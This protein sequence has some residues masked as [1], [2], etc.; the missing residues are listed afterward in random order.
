MGL[1]TGYEVDPEDSTATA[2]FCTVRVAPYGYTKERD[3]WN[4]PAGH[5]TP[6]TP[7]TV[8]P[9]HGCVL[10]VRKP[11]DSLPRR[12]VQLSARRGRKTVVAPPPL[13]PAPPLSLRL[14][15]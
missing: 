2:G 9:L 1:L 8:N 15:G 4:E 12:S 6:P 10:L 13:P 3:L 14:T 11:R 7:G 5:V